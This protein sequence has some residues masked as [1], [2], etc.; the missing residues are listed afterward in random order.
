MTWWLGKFWAQDVVDELGR[1]AAEFTTLPWNKQQME[2]ISLD[3]DGELAQTR[4]L[5]REA[6][7]EPTVQELMRE[8]FSELAVGANMCE[9]QLP[10]LRTVRDEW[11]EMV[12]FI[13]ESW[14]EQHPR[15]TS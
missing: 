1:R 7:K 11:L 3:H 9:K 10:E 12:E 8:V 4:K 5:L 15:P 2:R 13:S 14:N 6:C